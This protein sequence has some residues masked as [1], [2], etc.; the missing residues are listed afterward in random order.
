MSKKETDAVEWFISD[1]MGGLAAII[2]NI[3][4]FMCVYL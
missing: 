1:S 4:M 3:C 2:I